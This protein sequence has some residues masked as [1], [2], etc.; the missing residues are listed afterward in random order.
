ML[1]DLRSHGSSR[2][3]ILA[4]LL[5]SLA[6]A[7][8]HGA[9]PSGQTVATVNGESITTTDLKLELA[10]VPAKFRKQAEPL[11]LESLVQR[12]LL[13]QYAKKQGIDRS[14]DYVLQLRQAGD[15]LL[16]RRTLQ[17]T[18]SAARQPISAA[19]INQYLNGHPD[20]GSNR[21]I[22]LVDQLQ[23]L[24]PAADVMSELKPTMSIDAVLAVLQRHQIKA[25]RTQ[26]QL[27]TAALPDDVNA[28]ID[29]LQPGEPL[30]TVNGPGA[31]ASA[32]V[33]AK[34]APLE[35]EQA[36]AAARRRLQ[37]NQAQAAILQRQNV[38]R[39]DAKIDYAEGYK[40][41]ATAAQPKP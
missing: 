12:K 37:E 15:M 31:I 39:S 26:A 27:D 16:V 3:Q 22:L 34:P 6:L 25:Q 35:G 30:I 17:G 5:A 8:C 29:A 9:A 10:G 20:V 1:K 7:G 24:A 18:V 4:A 13:V 32:I 33:Q 2:G 38:L 41:A 23:F 40:P 36:Q 11:A 19:D 14:A 21:R 28:K